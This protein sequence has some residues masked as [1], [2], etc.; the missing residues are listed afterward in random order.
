MDVW[1]VWPT[2]MIEST[3]EQA[4]VDSAQALGPNT[5]F[6]YFFATLTTEAE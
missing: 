5:D 3:N 2:G 1:V 6:I 4:A